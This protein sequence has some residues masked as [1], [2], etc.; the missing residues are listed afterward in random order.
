MLDVRIISSLSDYTYGP[1]N[2]QLRWHPKPHIDT[3]CLP[4]TYELLPVSLN[5][6]DV[7]RSKIYTIR[8]DVS[9]SLSDKIHQGHGEVTVY[10]LSVFTQ[11]L[12]I[13]C[14]VRSM[15]IYIYIW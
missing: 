1:Y 8:R 5:S 15:Y 10:F 14:R 12:T 9:L 13:I 7:A 11:T 2:C 3:T 6:H 4:F